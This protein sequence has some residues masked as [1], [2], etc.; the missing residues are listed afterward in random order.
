MAS[1]AGEIEKLF[2][3]TSENYVQ[4]LACNNQSL[5]NDKFTNVRT[6]FGS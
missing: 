2:E 1:H 5:R 6:A 3:G 4:C